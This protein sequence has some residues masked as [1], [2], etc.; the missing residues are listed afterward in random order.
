MYYN[1]V[2]KKYIINAII[3]FFFFF[4]IHVWHMQNRAWWGSTGAH[5][6]GGVTIG[7]PTYI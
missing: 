4:L 3:P 6:R 1:I 7:A 2:L 5:V